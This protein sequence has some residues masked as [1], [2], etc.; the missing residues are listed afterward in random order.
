MLLSSHIFSNCG[1]CSFHAYP[2]NRIVVS[3]LQYLFISSSFLLFSTGVL[4]KFFHSCSLAIS[5]YQCGHILFVREAL[6]SMSLQP[7]SPRNVA[8]SS[9]LTDC[10]QSRSSLLYS[11]FLFAQP[12]KVHDFTRLSKKQ[13]SFTSYLPLPFSSG[14]ILD[15][16]TRSSCS[17]GVL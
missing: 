8:C 6:I 15:L 9:F 3:S 1:T 7:S 14:A 11:F 13:L 12:L 10:L 2:F 4:S 17:G 16:G 5:L